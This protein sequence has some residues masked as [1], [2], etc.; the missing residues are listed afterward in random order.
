[1]P[2]HEPA[3]HSTTHKD[4]MTDTPKPHLPLL[5]DDELE[6][7]GWPT[8]SGELVRLFGQAPDVFKR[9]NEWYR[10]LIADGAVSSRLKEIC[11]LRVAQLN[12]CAV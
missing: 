11:R 5:T 6:T 1:M 3:T 9:W 7:R 4:T 12:D 8:D 2:P 10:P